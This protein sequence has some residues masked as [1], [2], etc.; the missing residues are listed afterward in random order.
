MQKKDHIEE[1][2]TELRDHFDTESPAA[3]HQ[4]RFLEKLRAAGLEDSTPVK[5]TRSFPWKYLSIAASLALLIT[6][7]AGLFK[8]GLNQEN[9]D[10]EVRKAEVYFTSLIDTEMERIKSEVTPE[11]RV[12]VEDAMKQLDKLETDYRNIEDQLKAGGNNEQLL[13]AMIMNFQTRIDLLQEVLERMEQV[14]T[15]RNKPIDENQQHI[16]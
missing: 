7:G 5:A 13:H 3:G 10:P 11:T 8:G 12:L 6:L 15:M 14:K 16:L 4:D 2:F 1:L 9:E